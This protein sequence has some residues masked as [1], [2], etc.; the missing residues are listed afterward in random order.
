MIEETGFM[1]GPR[2]RLAY[3]RCAGGG[4]GVVWLGGFRSDMT[5]TKAAHLAAWAA[6]AGRAFLRFDYSGHGDSGGRF[7]DCVLSDWLGDALAAVD[8]LTEGPQILVG[9]SMGGWIAA[10]LALRRPTLV[11]GVV[12][13]APAPDF[14]EALLWEKMTGP[15]RD[16]ILRNGRLIERSDYSPEPTIITRA[17]IEDGRQ[18]LLL[19]GAIPIRCPVR[20]VQGMADPDVPWRHAMTFA[21]CLQTDDLTVT[22]L[23][24]GDHR[25]SKPH[26]LAE[27]I[28]ALEA[29]AV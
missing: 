27:I 17:L 5:G 15:E 28:A 2:C 26:E 18:H 19:G 20:I 8:A 14:T 10:L 7:E 4:P 11:A 23:K 22:L 6:G 13:I 12:F 25:L 21:E 29:L 24:A 9:S 16:E 1:D 3:R